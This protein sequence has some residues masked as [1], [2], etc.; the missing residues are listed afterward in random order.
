MIRILPFLFFGS[1]LNTVTAQNR[2]LDSLFTVTKHT[3][4]VYGSNYDNHDSLWTLLMDVYEPN[5]DTAALRPIIYFVHGGSFIHN[6]RT[7]QS[8]HKTAEYF[9]K[10]GYVTANIEYRVE[11]SEFEF[12]YLNFL[13]KNNWYRA[14]IRA[15]QDLKAAVRYI[16]EDVAANG[17]QYRVDTTKIF[18]YGSS[19]GA[20]TVLHAAYLDDTTEMRTSPFFNNYKQLGGLDGNSGSPGHTMAGIRAVVSCSGALERLD[21]I[22]NNTDIDYLGFHNTID[23]VVPYDVGC[24]DVV[25]CW[26]GYFNG[27]NKIFPRTQNL[28]MNS[29]FYRVQMP[30]HPVDA[31]ADTATHRMIWEKMTDFLYRILETPNLPTVVPYKAVKQLELRPTLSDGRF[32]VIE[33][34]TLRRQTVQLEIRAL[35]GQLMYTETLAPREQAEV[36]TNLPSGSYIVTLNGSAELYSGRITVIH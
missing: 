5:G 25:A 13:D 26:L 1:L 2:Y 33:P 35:N 34:E 27:G 29:E 24:F 20:I 31:T 8:I 36:R 19:A 18:L 21:Y 11:Q 17:N 28:G 23:P 15:T 14:I 7:D 4:V 16:K 30:G 32:L 12:I 6:S 9:A 3:D 10:K 22:N